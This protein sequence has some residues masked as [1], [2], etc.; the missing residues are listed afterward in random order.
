MGPA[1]W[2][3][4]FDDAQWMVI[5]YED[6][7]SVQRPELT[8]IEETILWAVAAAADTLAPKSKSASKSAQARG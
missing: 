4:R 5:N 7:F 1:H 6:P 8:E 3:I 2:A